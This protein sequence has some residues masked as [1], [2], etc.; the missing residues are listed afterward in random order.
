MYVKCLGVRQLL[1]YHC[2]IIW[3]AWQFQWLEYIN[4]AKSTCT[5]WLNNI[6]CLKKGSCSREFPWLWFSLICVVVQASADISGTFPHPSHFF[7][8]QLEHCPLE[9]GFPV[10][11][12]L[13]VDHCKYY[14]ETNLSV[15]HL[16]FFSK[17]LFQP[18]CLVSAFNTS[19]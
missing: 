19:H 3:V 14:D 12:N 1:L 15:V 8:N 6:S 10:L 17:V 16:H 18:V 2:Q 4:D 13:E 5:V 11:Q 7:H 9:I